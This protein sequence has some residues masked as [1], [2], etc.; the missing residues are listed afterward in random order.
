MYLSTLVA[1]KKDSSWCHVS[2]ENDSVLGVALWQRVEGNDSCA[3]T[4]LVCL[5]PVTQNQIT[6]VEWLTT[7]EIYLG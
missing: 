4:P 6:L 5:C 7:K 1:A 2:T 3:T